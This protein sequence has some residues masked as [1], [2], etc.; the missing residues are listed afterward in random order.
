MRSD[1]L[2]QFP[3]GRSDAVAAVAQVG[4][5]FGGRE[6]AECGGYERHHL[7]EVTRPRRA[8]EGLQF[9]KRE[10]NGIEVRPVRGQK[11]EVGAGLF[12]RRAHR[13]VLVHRQVVEDDDVTRP[14]RGD[15][16]L[17]DI[18]AETVDVD[19]P[20]KHRG[21]TYSVE[22]EGRNHGVRLPVA[23]GSVIAEAG[24]ARTAA[25]AAQQVGRDARFVD[26]HILSGVTQR[27]AISPLA[28]GHHDIR[29]ALFVGVYRSF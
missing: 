1:S 24:A 7:I 5:A 11:A 28:A 9:R 25:V 2:E 29:P 27:Q 12:D 4:G 20:V 8:E 10:F 6:E 14:Q 13:R 26:K 16:D 17:I 15:Q 18:G 3:L 22:A 19:G 23:A 21:R